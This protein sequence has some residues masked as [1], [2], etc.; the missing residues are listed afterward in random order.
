MPAVQAS[1]AKE[2]GIRVLHALREWETRTFQGIT[3]SDTDRALVARLGEGGEGRL[4]IDELRDGLRVRARSWVGV[5][6]LE[7][8]EIRIV[9]KLAGD[10]VGLVRLLEFT[11]GL[12]GLWRFDTEAAVEVAGDSLLDLV[13]LLF[14]EATEGVVRR[15]L[16]AGY[17]EREEDLGVVRGRILADRQILERFG[18]LDRIICRFDELEHDVD[19][20]RLL[21]AALRVAARRVQTPSVHRR[22][23]RLRA[24][25]EPVCDPS[26]LDLRALRREITYNRLNAHYE[27]AH[28][29]A[30]LVLDALGIDDLLA[31]GSTRSFA[32]LLDMNLLFAPGGRGDRTPPISG[33]LAG[34]PFLDHLERGNPEALLTGD[35]GPGGAAAGDA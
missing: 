22:L 6:R 35:P 32:F 18:R 34:R 15:G 4:Q 26:G 14:A 27:R 3:L 28:A 7:T 17:I 13:A 11:S 5:V 20:N 10:Q 9:P 2:G 21:L 19:E 29:L 12:E 23:G 1:P 30:W 25:L 16:M 24:V 31:L 8:V 33:G